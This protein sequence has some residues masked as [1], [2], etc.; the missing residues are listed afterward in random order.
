MKVCIEYDSFLVFDY[1]KSILIEHIIIFSTL[2]PFVMEEN[3]EP[4]HD[5]TNKVT[6]RPAMTQIS[7]GIRSV[8]SESSL[9]AQW[10]TKNPSFLHAASEDSDQIGR[11][12]R[13]I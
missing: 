7:L 9:C 12:P 11:M 1:I 6:V 13:L 2:I 4:R 8:L 5:K 10:V 3:N